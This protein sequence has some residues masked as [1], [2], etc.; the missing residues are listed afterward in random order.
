MTTPVFT[1]TGPILLQP[2][3]AKSFGVFAAQ[4][5]RGRIFLLIKSE[6]HLWGLWE[7][8]GETIEARV[9]PLPGGKMEAD[10]SMII[11]DNRIVVYYSSRVGT[12][13]RPAHACEISAPGVRRQPT[14]A[15]VDA[16]YK[17][18]V[19]IRKRLD[20]LAALEERVTA[21]EQRQRDAGKALSGA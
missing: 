13:P 4:D 7:Q 5:G 17:E 8:V 19:P 20:G 3:D 15:H 12:D 18:F 21:L 6:E 14:L 16:L 2:P 11:H 1:V 9:V 10:A